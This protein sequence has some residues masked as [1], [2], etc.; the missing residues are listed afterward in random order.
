MQTILQ[1]ILSS[2]IRAEI[3]RLLFGVKTEELHLREIS[4]QSGLAV[5]T[6]QQELKKLLRHELVIAKKDGN[7]VCYFPN[8]AHPLFPDIRSIVL[9]TAGLADVLRDALSSDQIKIAFVFGSIAENKE[10]ASSDVDL[11]IIG[12]IGLR[13]ASALLAGV[14]EKIG[15]EIN[16]HTMSEEELASRAKQ[17]DHFIKSVLAS[18]KLFIRGDARELAGLAR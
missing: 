17:K 18:R 5:G 12:K 6:V 13:Q 4:R 15:R 11:F 16:A 14:S 3:F 1:D 7:R 10:K 8:V 2:A 9:K